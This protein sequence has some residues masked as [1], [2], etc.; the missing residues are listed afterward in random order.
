MAPVSA[1][2][3]LMMFSLLHVLGVFIGSICCHLLLVK[4]ELFRLVV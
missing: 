2:H 3:L 1:S 4:V